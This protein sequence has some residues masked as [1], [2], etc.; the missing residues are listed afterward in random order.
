MSALEAS[1]SAISTFLPNPIRNQVTPRA[2]SSGLSAN[3]RA[4]GLGG[5]ELESRYPTLLSLP[6]GECG[7]TGGIISLWWRMGPAIRWGKNVTKEEIREEILNLRLSLGEI[8]EVGDL[9]ESE[10]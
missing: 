6:P 10:K 4:G 5:R 9:G 8:H 7:R 2:T 3:R 1:L